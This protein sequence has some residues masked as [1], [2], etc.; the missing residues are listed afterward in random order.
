M[1]KERFHNALALALGYERIVKNKRYHITV[2]DDA[3]EVV[4]RIDTVDGILKVAYKVSDESKYVWDRTILPEQKEMI[5]VNG[6]ESEMKEIFDI[7]HQ[8]YKQAIAPL[9]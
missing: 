2:D 6:L 5:K 8:A 7:V 4:V 9:F 1:N 3:D